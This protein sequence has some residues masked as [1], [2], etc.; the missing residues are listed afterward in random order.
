[1]IYQD[2][3]TK[4]QRKQNLFNNLSLIILKREQLVCAFVCDIRHEAQ[5]SMLIHELWAK[6]KFHFVLFLPKQIKL[7]K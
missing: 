7:V 6:V 4:Y 2:T 1:L 5:R 3:V